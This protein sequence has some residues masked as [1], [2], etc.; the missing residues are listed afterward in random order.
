MTQQYSE[1]QLGALQ[2]LADFRNVFYDEN[3][4]VRTHLLQKSVN[5]FID[6]FCQHNFANA[7]YTTIQKKPDEFSTIDEWI[8]QF[9][10]DTVLAAITYIIWTNRSHKGYLM[11]KIKDKII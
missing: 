1:Y 2:Q 10:I 7:D 4:N 11:R 6:L 9:D 8:N 3:K 5:S